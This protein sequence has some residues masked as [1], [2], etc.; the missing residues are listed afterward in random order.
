MHKHV[1]DLISYFGEQNE[2]LDDHELDALEEELEALDNILDEDDIFELAK[3]SIKLGKPDILE[4]LLEKSDF[5]QTDLNELTKEIKNYIKKFE[6]QEDIIED[7]KKIMKN[8]DKLPYHKK[9]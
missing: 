3:F 5:N 4:I 8:Y 6:N 7:F 2:E 9:R 1:K